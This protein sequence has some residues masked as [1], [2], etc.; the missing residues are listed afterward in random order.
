[1]VEYFIK[2]ITL[3]IIILLACITYPLDKSPKS[4][5]GG[6]NTV[7]PEYTCVVNSEWLGTDYIMSNLPNWT[8][9]PPSNDTH[10]SFTFID[11]DQY[12]SKEMYGVSA[13]L[14]YRLDCKKLMDKAQLHKILSKEAPDT[15]CKTIFV[16]DKTK[17]S[18]GEV[19]MVRSNLGHVGSKSVAV[20]NTKDLIKLYRRWNRGRDVIMA[21]EYIAK[22]MLYLGKKFHLRVYIIVFIPEGTKQRRAWMLK[23]SFLIPALENY[24]A[25]NWSNKNIH[26]THGFGNPNVKVFPRDA[27]E[28]LDTPRL[29]KNMVNMLTEVFQI[30]VNSVENYP[31]STNGYELFGADVMFTDSGAPKLI[32]VNSSPAV[33]LLRDNTGRGVLNDNIFQALLATAFTEVFYPA[34]NPQLVVNLV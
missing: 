24:A 2:M 25:V 9:V 32:E 28:I 26:D 18:P 34:G 6:S 23:E 11:G 17:V 8:N 10:V 31:E 7:Q 19:W 22:P 3:F 12:S 20:D 1:M 27:L 16:T 29:C 4:I 30:M 33:N 14:K 21:S 5:T 15:I 13:K